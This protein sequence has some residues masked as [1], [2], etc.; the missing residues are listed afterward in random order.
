M[1][2]TSPTP[3]PQNP[4]LYYR[5]LTPNLRI[6]DLVEKGTL[7]AWNEGC[8]TSSHNAIPGDWISTW[9]R[10]RSKRESDYSRL[11]DG[12]EYT[13]EAL[14]TFLANADCHAS[15]N[16]WTQDLRK[17][18]GA[19]YGVS[20]F[21]NPSGALLYAEATVCPYFVVFE[22]R[23]LGHLPPEEGDGGVRVEVVREVLPPVQK[24][25]FLNWLRDHV[26]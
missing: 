14:A 22:G 16:T 8:R 20:A 5:V 24:A 19:Y 2:S 25:S 26:H 1:R 9:L 6:G 13:P 4:P 15:S 3:L 12:V 11:A 10:T 21:D 7:A 23:L 17:Q 18:I